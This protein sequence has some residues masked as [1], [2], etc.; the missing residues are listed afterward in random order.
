[1]EGASSADERGGP[2]PAPTD[3]PQA[4]LAV[5]LLE[6]RPWKPRTVGLLGIIASAINCYMLT[7]ARPAAV[8]VQPPPRLAVKTS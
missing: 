6:L 7:P 5:G 8:V 1:M 4:L 3:C 2:D